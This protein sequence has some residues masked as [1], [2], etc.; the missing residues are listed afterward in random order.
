MGRMLEIG[1]VQETLEAWPLHLNLSLYSSD[2][3]QFQALRRAVVHLTNLQY[4][5][6]SR[7][8]A[9]AFAFWK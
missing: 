5:I 2:V 1:S 4:H 6:M 3:F 9:S 7:H 8:F